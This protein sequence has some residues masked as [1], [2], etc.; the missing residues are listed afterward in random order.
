MEGQRFSHLNHQ[1]WWLFG[2]PLPPQVTLLRDLSVSG[3]AAKMNSAS[4]TSLA[5]RNLSGSLREV[6]SLM[7]LSA[8]ENQK[9]RF[10]KINS[11]EY[12]N[13]SRSQWSN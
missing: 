11:Q 4:Q 8:K 6:L 10:Q 12:M 2:S 1:F 3:T 7:I 5:F 13:S 9:L